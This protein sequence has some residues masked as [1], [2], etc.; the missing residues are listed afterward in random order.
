MNF[1]LLNGKKFANLLRVF[2]FFC[3][4]KKFPITNFFLGLKYFLPSFWKQEVIF[5][6]KKNLENLTIFAQGKN[7]QGLFFLITPNNKKSGKNF[8][9]VLR[10]KFR[11]FKTPKTH[12]KIPPPFFDCLFYFF[13]KFLV[14]KFGKF[15]IKRFGFMP[16]FCFLTPP[17][18]FQKFPFLAKVPSVTA[19]APPLEWK[20]F[21]RIK[22]TAPLGN[23]PGAAPPKKTLGGA[24]QL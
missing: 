2:F 7:F 15:F 10:K 8:V 9:L 3:S 12:P 18:N 16:I 21:Y 24:P 11:N 5:C 6:S 22:K 23:G 20:I 14:A 17:Q 13:L 4:S 19:N 1:L